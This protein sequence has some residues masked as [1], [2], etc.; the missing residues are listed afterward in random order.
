MSIV[1][2]AIALNTPSFGWILFFLVLSSIVPSHAVVG[3]IVVAVA[4][5]IVAVIHGAIGARPAAIVHIITGSA[6]VV[7]MITAC[8][9]CVE[10]AELSYIRILAVFVARVGSPVCTT[11]SIGIIPAWFA[12][13]LLVHIF[14]IGRPLWCV[15]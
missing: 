8:A 11:S 13:S 1:V 6:A 7:T 3:D 4:T 12:G 10:A 15:P 9:K 14:L 5:A 2:T